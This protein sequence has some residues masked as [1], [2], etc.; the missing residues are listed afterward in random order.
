MPPLVLTKEEIQVVKLMREHVDKSIMDTKSVVNVIDITIDDL[1][2]WLVLPLGS[3]KGYAFPL[4]TFWSRFV[5][6]Y[7]P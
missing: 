6:F 4:K 7:S 3:K 5:N 2:Y 1:L